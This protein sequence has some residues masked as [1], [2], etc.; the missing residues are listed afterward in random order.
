MFTARIN[1]NDHN[2]WE[3]KDN[4]KLKYYAIIRCKTGGQ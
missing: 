3:D 1:H 2:Q 4:M